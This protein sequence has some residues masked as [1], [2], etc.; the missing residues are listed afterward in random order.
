MK[1]IQCKNKLLFMFC[2]LGLISCK[3]SPQNQ[4]DAN[5]STPRST[6][7]EGRWAGKYGLADSEPNYQIEFLLKIGGDVEIK[8]GETIDK[9]QWTLT[10]SDVRVTYETPRTPGAIFLWTATYDRI[11]KKLTNGTWGYQ[12][13]LE[14][15]GTWYMDK[16]E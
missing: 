2:M 15:V 8:Q 6:V 3:K 13:F 7:I 1:A 9:G 10:G 5:G 14:R 12:G 16:V 4:N 11:N